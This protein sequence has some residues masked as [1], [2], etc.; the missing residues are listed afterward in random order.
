M[1]REIPSQA[2]T[3]PSP[4]ARG[5]RVGEA[6]RPAA[7]GS[8]PASAGNPRSRRPGR[9]RRRVHPRE[10]GESLVASGGAPAADGPSPRARGILNAVEGRPIGLG[11]IPAS[12]GNPADRGAPAD[13]VRVHP[14]ERGE[15]DHRP[16][17]RLPAPGPSPRA[18]GIRRRAYPAP[19]RRGSIPASA[20]NP[21]FYLYAARELRVH[22]RE[23]GESAMGL[24]AEESA[25]GPSPRARGILD[26]HAAAADGLRS[27][28]ASAGNP[29]RRRPGSR[30]AW[31]HPRER[32]ESTSRCRSAASMPGPSPRARG[33]PAP[34]R[35][36]RRRPGSIPAS[37]GNP[38]PGRAPRSKAWVH[39]RE[40]GESVTAAV[41]GVGGAGPSPRARGILLD[42]RVGGVLPRSIPASAGNPTRR[43]RRR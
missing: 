4:R 12:A 20:G 41:A 32:G 19:M 23:R 14:R 22:P 15:S 10:R 11:S 2:V 17:A 42:R 36:A 29:S 21:P 6:A 9:R 1:A 24:S 26:G 33:I 43:G 34:A 18:R 25:T 27:I 28:P 37:A 40:R 7:H 30:W 5:I 16:R 35:S 8:I 31:V 3:G 38:R 13:M 39:P